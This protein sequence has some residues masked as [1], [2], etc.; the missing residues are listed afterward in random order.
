[1]MLKFECFIAKIT[2]EFSQLGTH[3]MAHHVSLQS[4]Q[5]VELLVTYFTTKNNI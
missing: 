2:F 5:I 4:M 1:M 3:V